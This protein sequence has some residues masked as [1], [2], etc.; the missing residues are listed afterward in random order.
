[1]VKTKEL[2]V[3]VFSPPFTI[4]ELPAPVIAQGI[5]TLRPPKSS[6]ACHSLPEGIRCVVGPTGLT[7]NHFALR[8]LRAKRA[9]SQLNVVEGGGSRTWPEVFVPLNADTDWIDGVAVVHISGDMFFEESASLRILVK[10]LLAQSGKIVFDLGNVTHIDSGG[11]GALVSAFASV[12]RFGG[13]I[14]FANPGEH[15]REVLRITKLV[16]V[17]KIFDSTE[18]AIASFN[19]TSTGQ[20]S[21]NPPL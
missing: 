13:D 4:P 10:E 11:V 17:F 3:P 20:P 8:V 2:K 21:S 12:R 16:K 5:A 6:E 7:D 9:G 18:D 14:K 1:V 19:Q 15:A